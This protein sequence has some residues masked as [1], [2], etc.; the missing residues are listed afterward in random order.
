MKQEVKAHCSFFSIKWLI[1]LEKFINFMKSP[2][3]IG[4]KGTLLKDKL[5]KEEFNSRK[6]IS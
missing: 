3:T 5:D 4:K 2:K 1:K 6:M